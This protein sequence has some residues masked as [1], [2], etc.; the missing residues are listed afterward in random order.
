[1]GI[2]SLPVERWAV[3]AAEWNPELSTKHKTYRA[4]GRPKRRWEDEINEFLN[5]EETETTTGNDMKYNSAWIKV[6]KKNEE[7]G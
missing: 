6:A 3:Q 2:A 4:I 5:P 1:M 7:D